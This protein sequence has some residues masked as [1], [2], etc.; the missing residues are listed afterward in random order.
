V[1]RRSYKRAV[2]TGVAHGLTSRFI[3][4]ALNGRGHLWSI[5]LPPPASPEL[6]KEIGVAVGDR[7]RQD[8]SLI[9]GSSRKRLPSLLDTIAPI[10]MFVHDSHHS[11]HNMLFEMSRAWPTIRPGG[12]MVVD[13]IDVNW[14]YHEFSKMVT[15]AMLI[16][17]AEPIRPDTR[18]FNQKGLFG[19]ILKPDLSAP[20]LQ[21]GSPDPLA[22]PNEG[23]PAATT[24]CRPAL[25]AH[26]LDRVVND[27][28]QAGSA[29][30]RDS[31]RSDASGCQPATVATAS[32]A[33]ARIEA[34]GARKA[35]NCRQPPS[36]TSS[37]VDAFVCD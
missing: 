14:A 3:L 6:H 16:G 31:C 11:E 13:D 9:F 8:W 33:R 10:D 1:I 27:Q 21:S 24:I 22:L 32:V 4:E 36:V 15:G 28:Q 18:R 30:S 5:D 34:G 25:F 19:V 29:A 35:P 12:A 20:A 26:A 23:L 37:A 7:S 17:E 2:E